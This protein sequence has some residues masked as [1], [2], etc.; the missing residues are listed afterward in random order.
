MFLIFYG[1]G[2]SGCHGWVISQS[3]K[4]LLNQNRSAGFHEPR[5]SC[6]LFRLIKQEAESD[7]DSEGQP[8]CGWRRNSE[9]K[10]T[11]VVR[12]QMADKGAGI[13]NAASTHNG[14]KWKLKKKKKTSGDV[15]C[16]LK[17]YQLYFNSWPSYIH[18]IRIQHWSSFN[19]DS[20]YT[21]MWAWSETAMTKYNF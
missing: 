18:K 17:V 1:N 7:E 19:A 2:G 12:E 11:L 14:D 3:N 8:T 13:C 21:K 15:Y 9:K 5:A 20:S 16:L 4:M 6:W 10:I